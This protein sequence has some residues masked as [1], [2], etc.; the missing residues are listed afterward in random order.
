MVTPHC[1]RLGSLRTA[2][3]CSVNAM[4]ESPVLSHWLDLVLTSQLSLSLVHSI[5]KPIRVHPESVET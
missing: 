3:V 2:V 1:T 4:V 5:R